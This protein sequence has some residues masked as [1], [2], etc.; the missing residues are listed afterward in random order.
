MLR[1]ILVFTL[2]SG[3]AVQLVRGL[4][5]R[6]ARR[7]AQIDREAVRTWEEE[8][9]AVRPAEPAARRPPLATTH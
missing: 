7:D 6:K 1:K 9:G 5:R 3:L 8:G 4:S 2:T